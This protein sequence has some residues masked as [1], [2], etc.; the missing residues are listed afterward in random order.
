ME[1]FADKSGK[2]WPQ[3]PHQKSEVTQWLYWQMANQGPQMG[4]Q[5]H[6]RRASQKPQNGNQAYALLRFDGEV[7]RIYG[8]MNLGLRGLIRRPGSRVAA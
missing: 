6:F 4:E 2:S 7:H 5:G 8:V 1:Y 3:E